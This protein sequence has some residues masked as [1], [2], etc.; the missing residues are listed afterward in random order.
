VS[1]TGFGISEENLP[2]IFEKFYRVADHEG[3]TQGTGLGLAVAKR[4]VEGHGGRIAVE[5][6]V[7]VGTTFT[8]TLPIPEE[9]P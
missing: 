6:E 4:I 2:H 9:A 3:F 5:S 8:F 1:D 7:G